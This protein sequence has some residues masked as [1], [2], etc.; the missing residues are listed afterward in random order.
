MTDSAS[1]RSAPTYRSQRPRVPARRRLAILFAD[2]SDF[3]GLVESFEPEAVY[4]VVGPLMDELIR[5]VERHDGEVQQVLGDGFMCAFGLRAQDGDEA[6]RAVSAGLALV[7]AAAS[8][9]YPPIHVGIE[10]G[11]V[12]VTRSWEPA[13]FGVWGRVVNLARRL[14]ELAGPGGIQMGPG[15]YA[16]ARPG[17]WSALPVRVRL[18]GIAQAVQAHAITATPEPALVG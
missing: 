8:G 10:Y 3:T 17:A 7:A 16:H 5:H 2:I 1:V 13:G 14:C 12:L 18:K 4:A 9:A 11:E 15:A 6:G